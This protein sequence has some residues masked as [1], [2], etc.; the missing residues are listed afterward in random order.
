VGLADDRQRDLLKRPQ[1]V[2]DAP[3]R[4]PGLGLQVAGDREGGEHD[5]QVRFDRV[6]G[7]VE[8]RSGSK[9]G[10]RHA[11]RLLDVPEVVVVVDDL[12]GVIS[13]SGMLVT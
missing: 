5:G 9:V 13:A 1:D 11:E 4:D 3:D 10:L 7:V 8:H 12:A 2:H 6:S